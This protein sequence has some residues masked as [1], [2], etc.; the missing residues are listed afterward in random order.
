[1]EPTK[2]YKREYLEAWYTVKTKEK[3]ERAKEVI[4]KHVEKTAVV[5]ISGKDSLVSLAI[6]AMVA[7][8]NPKSFEFTAVVGKYFIDRE[9]PTK[10]VNELVEIAKQ[11]CD[12]YIFEE[13]WNVHAD[14]FALIAKRYKVDTIISGIRNSEN[15]FHPQVEY[16]WWG[17]LINP[18]SH[19]GLR[20]VWAFIAHYRIRIPNLYY[21]APVPWARLQDLMF[22]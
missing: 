13:K 11:F 9:I 10:I 14:L 8:E 1:M 17:K 3:E 12:V 18:I 2:F 5:A 22:D 4:K 7:K 21:L 15:G 6:T 20:D 16:R 19:W